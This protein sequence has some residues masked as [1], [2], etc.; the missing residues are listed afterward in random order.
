MVQKVNYQDVSASELVL[1]IVI[2]TDGTTYH[3]ENLLQIARA[4]YESS[5]DPKP[6]LNTEEEEVAFLLASGHAI[7]EKDR[8]SVKT[9]CINLPS[10]QQMRVAELAG[11]K[12]T[13]NDIDVCRLAAYMRFPCLSK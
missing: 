7:V 13:N 2:M 1:P 9:Y 6:N 3:G 10:N 12:L 8:R 4:I 5:T 11:G